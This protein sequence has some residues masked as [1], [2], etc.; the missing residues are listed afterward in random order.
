MPTARSRTLPRMTNS[1]NSLNIVPPHS[2]ASVA[3]IITF[4]YGQTAKLGF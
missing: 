2:D 3:L 4:G 1:L